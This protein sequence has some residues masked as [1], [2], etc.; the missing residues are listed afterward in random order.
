[1]PTSFDTFFHP[2]PAPAAAPP[3]DRFT[4]PFHYTPH[5]LALQAV[6]CLQDHLRNQTEWQH[7]FGHNNEVEVGAKGKMF[8]VLVVENEAGELGFLAAYSG[9]LANSNHLPGFVPPVYDVLLAEGFYKKGE[10]EVNAVNAQLEALEQAPELALAKEN[11][12]RTQAQAKDEIAKEKADI[13]AAKQDRKRQR[14]AARATMSPEQVTAL[15]EQ[16]ARESVG[17]HFGM[18]D[19]VKAW[20]K[21]IE[22]ATRELAVLTD[23][24]T[25]L[26]TLRKTMSNDLQHRIFAEYRFLDANGEVRDLTD[27]FKDTIFKTPPAGAGECAAPKLLQFAYLHSYK[28]V[29]MA[30]FW[31]GQSPRSEIRKHGHYYPACRGKCEPILS[32]MLVGLEVDPNPMLENPAAGKEL[33]I[34]FQDDHLLVVNKPHEFLSVPGRNIEDSVWLRIKQQFPEATGPLI[35]HRLDMS[36]SGLLLL[37]KTKETHKLLQHQF[38]KR[39]VKKRYVALLEGEV[40]GDEGIIDLPLRGDIEDRP[41]Q[42]VCH[43]HGKTSRTHW[44]VVGRENGRT[45]VHLW[46][47][48]GRTHQLRVH[49]A[50]PHGL[51]TPII[52]DDLYGQPADRLHLHAE[53]ISFIHPHT[54]EE[55]SFEVKATF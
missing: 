43:E 32:H 18:K 1:M 34:V 54:K 39:S 9:K 52:G 21:R 30:E 23:E 44:K 26:K 24:I 36:T 20:D 55:V 14:E 51:N 53:W 16:L 49:C 45:R 28:P 22:T 47:V 11:L 25:R 33:P 38:F 46:P 8:G 31:W 2:F 42:I 7:D 4:F 12:A 41:R 37:T 40:A 27:I 19:L 35:V 10:K 29:A 3:P 50:H 17:R 15:E 48:T 6:A 5:P 13:K